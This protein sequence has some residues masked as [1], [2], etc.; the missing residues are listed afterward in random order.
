[1][2]RKEN[3]LDGFF[4]NRF[5]FGAIF[6]KLPFLGH[7]WPFLSYLAKII[8]TAPTILLIFIDIV[9]RGGYLKFIIAKYGAI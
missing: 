5:R 6:K 8:K 4:S 2:Y 3:L 9:Y 1:M 7:F